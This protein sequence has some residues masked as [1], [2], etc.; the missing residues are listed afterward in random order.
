MFSS[1]FD[2]MQGANSLRSTWHIAKDPHSKHDGIVI[3]SFNSFIFYLYFHKP[4][5]Q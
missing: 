5:I 2:H 4:S 3:F 1:L